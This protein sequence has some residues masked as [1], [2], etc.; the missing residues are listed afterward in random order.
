MVYSSIWPR[1]AELTPGNRHI[2][3]GWLDVLVHEERFMPERRGLLGLHANA[4]ITFSL[5]AMRV[6]SRAPC[7]P[8]LVPSPVEATLDCHDVI[9]GTARARVRAAL[10]EARQRL[11]SDALAQL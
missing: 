3:R 8:G 2:Q 1:T 9:G 10:T 5:E 6:P 7:P 11:S 4:G